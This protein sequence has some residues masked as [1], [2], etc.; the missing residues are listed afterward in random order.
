MDDNACMRSLLLRLALVS[1]LLATLLTVTAAPA[2]AFSDVG[3][4][5]WAY[6]AIMYV[7]NDNTWMQ[8]Y[9]PDEFQPDTLELR[10]FLARTMVQIWAPLETIDP[11]ITFDD[12]P[13]DDPFYPYANVAVKLDWLN[14]KNGG[15]NP[16]GTI[17]SRKLDRSLILALGLE[18]PMDGLD[19]IHQEDGTPYDTPGNFGAMQLARWL[20][21]HYNHD[22]ES[23]DLQKTSKVPRDEVA[24]SIYQ[25]VTLD[26]WQLDD[27]SMFVDITLPD[28][29]AV[30]EAFTQ[31][32][33]DEIGPPYIWAGEWD[34]ASP[35]GYCCG[36]QPQGGFDC[37]GW[38]WW[39]LKKN[40]SGYNAAQYHPAYKGWHLA[41]RSSSDMAANAPKHL[42]W[43]ELGPGNLM[44]FASNGGN[45][46]GDVDHVGIYLGNNWMFQ[47]TG[48]GPQLAW[49]GD[50]W[51]F[52]NFVW[53][54]GLKSTNP[55]MPE[56]RSGPSSSQFFSPLAGE[57]AVAP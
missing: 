39:T 11:T 6:D 9:G 19:A 21:L 37:S 10:K 7:A 8:D 55:Q 18:A 56:R 1:C 29:T 15:F 33:I 47:S 16:D 44:F 13:A 25:A 43:A 27:T 17:K 30:Q 54:R 23:Q 35:N 46:A 40:E 34:K 4:K 41:E 38:V 32:M 51:Y 12:L 52:D 14:K 31:Y 53:G 45:H 2:S 57:P 22:D 3:N 36:S 49:V 42:K 28:V 50:G 26:Q 20:D 48:G 5:H 24:W